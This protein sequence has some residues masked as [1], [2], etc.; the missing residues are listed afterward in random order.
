MQV[1][2]SGKMTGTS[3][4]HF[5]STK[6]GRTHLNTHTSIIKCKVSEDTDS[7]AAKYIM[8]MTLLWATF[9]VNMNKQ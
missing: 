6:A 2:R 8:K 4:Y 7:S 3:S 5:Q 1:T 9:N